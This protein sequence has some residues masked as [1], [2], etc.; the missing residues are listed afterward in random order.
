VTDEGRIGSG[1]IRINCFVGFARKR[2]IS[3][4]KFI[5]WSGT[6]VKKIIS[7]K[8]IE[9]ALRHV[10]RRIKARS[11]LE[12]QKSAV[13]PPHERKFFRHFLRSYFL[14]N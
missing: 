7:C 4:A 6:D 13:R 14:D 12:V 3:G 1:E 9:C 2:A 10:G 11:A 5:V 8:S